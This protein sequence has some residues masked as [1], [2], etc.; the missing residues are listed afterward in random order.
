MQAAKNPEFP[1]AHFDGHN[2]L[3]KDRYGIHI[4]P[5]PRCAVQNIRDLEFVALC[6]N[7]DEVTI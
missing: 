5:R 1:M 2:I 6:E 3:G 7:D 4:K